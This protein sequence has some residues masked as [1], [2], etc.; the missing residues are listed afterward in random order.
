MHLLKTKTR[1]FVIF[2]R[3]VRNVMNNK[4][5]MSENNENKLRVFTFQSWSTFT[6][7]TNILILIIFHNILLAII[8]I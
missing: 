6:N 8:D 3:F 5:N 1:K 7:T 2:C 4:F